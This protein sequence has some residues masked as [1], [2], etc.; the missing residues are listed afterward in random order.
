MR[1]FL[2]NLGKSCLILWQLNVPIGKNLKCER[3]N[4][5]RVTFKVPTP[6]TAF[7]PKITPNQ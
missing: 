6:V 1:K 5:Q 3:N 4:Q 7:S 2:N